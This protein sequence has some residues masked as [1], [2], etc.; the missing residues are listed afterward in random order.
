MAQGS[1]ARTKQGGVREP[2]GAGWRSTVGV[3]TAHSAY[4][5]VSILCQYFLL[6]FWDPRG[7]YN[8]DSGLDWALLHT[9]FALQC[10]VL[11]QAGTIT[12]ATF[13]LMMSLS[14]KSCHSSIQGTH[15]STL[16][17]CEVLGKLLFAAVAGRLLDTWGVLQ[18]RPD[19]FFWPFTFAQICLHGKIATPHNV[20]QIISSKALNTDIRVFFACPVKSFL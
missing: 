10:M 6:L 18:V 20:G 14:Q 17:T 3:I 15:Y 19:T 8:E 9:G 1:E 2:D 4:R 7:R 12:T 16:A 11:F 13:S 5:A